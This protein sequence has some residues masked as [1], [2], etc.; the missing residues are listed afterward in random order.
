MIPKIIHNIWLDGYDNISEDIKIN[1]MN[2]KKQNPE[3]EFMIWDNT[4]IE[5][6]LQ[7]YGEIYSIYKKND[8]KAK[9]EI[10]KYIILKEYGGLYCDTDYNCNSSLD[11]LFSNTNENENAIFITLNS[12]TLWDILYPFQKNKYN[13]SF[14]AMN[15]NHVVW[16]IVLNQLKYANSSFKIHYALDFSLKENENNISL[17]KRNLF[18]IIILDKVNSNYYQCK[19]KDSICYKS[20]ST[21]NFIIYLFQ[22]VNCHFIQLCLLILTICIIIFVEYLYMYN[23]KIYGSVNFIPG[24][25]GVPPATSSKIQKKKAERR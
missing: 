22:Y 5:K 2:I 7:K 8:L 12:Y 24:I 4:M 20:E 16:D 9:N 25:P 17:N 15:K 10:A 11:N 13:S 1:Y 21:S 19:S 23:V 18:P 6:L 14:I 3:W